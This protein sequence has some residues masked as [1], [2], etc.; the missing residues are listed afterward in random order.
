M[1]DAKLE[2]P[3]CGNMIGIYRIRNDL[4]FQCVTENCLQLS[5]NTSMHGRALEQWAKH[6]RKLCK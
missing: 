2:C 6:L 3:A 5:V 4:E 1:V